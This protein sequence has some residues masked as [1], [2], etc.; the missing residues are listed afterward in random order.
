[1][2][3]KRSP[4]G[5]VLLLCVSSAYAQCI[6]PPFG[7]KSFEGSSPFGVWR[8]NGSTG[9]HMGVDLVNNET[10]AR[11]HPPLYAPYDGVA[12]LKMGNGGAGNTVDFKRSDGVVTTFM[13]LDSA[14]PALRNRVSTSVKAGQLIGFTGGTG[15]NYKV[16]LHLGMKAPTSL[17]ID[18]RGKMMA[19]GGRKVDLDNKP[20]TADRIKSGYRPKSGLVYV[21][22]QFWITPQFPWQSPVAKYGIPMAGGKSLP[23]TCGAAP[24]VDAA[25]Q[26]MKDA[27]GGDPSTMTPEQLDAKG[28]DDGSRVGL[29]EAPDTSSYSDLSEREIIGMEGARRMTDAGWATQVAEAGSRGLLIELARIKAVQ[30]F[31]EQRVEEKKKRV[32]ALYAALIA[33]RTKNVAA[34]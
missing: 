28:I 32:E 26:Q 10:R 27:L 24:A 21:D 18:S 13:H 11:R 20:F 25:Q 6:A 1:M 12:T 17:A 16:H 15:G 22:P 14:A 7:G 3:N 29:V 2:P 8:T 31:V 33:I 34:R 30:L 4:I 5:I 9:W 19:D 23:A